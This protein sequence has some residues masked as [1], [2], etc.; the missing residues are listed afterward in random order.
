MYYYNPFPYR[1]EMKRYRSE[2]NSY[3][4]KFFAV[5]KYC[6]CSAIERA[7]EECRT[8]GLLGFLKN[9]YLFM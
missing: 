3:R 7:Q 1:E 9:N 4:T 2:R 6:N 8:S 5:Q